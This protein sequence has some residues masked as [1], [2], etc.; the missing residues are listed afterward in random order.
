MCHSSW[1]EGKRLGVGAAVAR[2]VVC[3]SEELEQKMRTVIREHCG[4]GASRRGQLAQLRK[5]QQRRV[6][7]PSQGHGRKERPEFSRHNW[8]AESLQQWQWQWQGNS[9][10]LH[11]Q[12]MHNVAQ[13]TA[14]LE[15]EEQV[16]GMHRIQ[17]SDLCL[18]VIC[19]RPFLDATPQLIHHTRV[20]IVVSPRGILRHE[21]VLQHRNR[22]HVTRCEWN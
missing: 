20:L 11:E 8:A 10:R 18:P 2:I 19:T 15:A 5:D 21:H 13:E 16:I 17:T 7:E 3:G 22:A 1:S 4:C 12:R 6:R 14:C 9:E